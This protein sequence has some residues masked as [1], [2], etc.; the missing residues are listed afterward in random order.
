MNEALAPGAECQ[1]TLLE[2]TG[3]GADA[4]TFSE[5]SRGRVLSC[6]LPLVRRDTSP[7]KA[8]TCE[9]VAEVQGACPDVMRF[10]GGGVRQP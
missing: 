9:E 6:R 7:E 1:A 2:R 8:P 3:C 4:F 5:P 10:L